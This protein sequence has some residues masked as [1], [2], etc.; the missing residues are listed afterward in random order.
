MTC[1]DPP[2]ISVSERA[3]KREISSYLSAA[4]IP[5][6]VG[7]PQSPARL[8]K[9]P[10][11]TAL[12]QLGAQR[13][14][15]DR[16]FFSLI[17][18]QHQYIVAEA[19]RSHALAKAG[20]CTPG[21]EIYLGVSKLDITFGVCPRTIAT[22]T[23]ETGTQVIRSPNVIGEKD[24][25]IIKDFV[26]DPHY[27]QCPYVTGF[28][29]MRSYA[30]VPITSPL[31]YVLGS[32]CVVHNEV[33]DFD[34]DATIFI[35]R[36]ISQTIMEHLDLVRIKQNRL[37]S[38]QLIKGLNVFVRQ[39]SQHD[40][41]AEVIEVPDASGD[42]SCESS[43]SIKAA[44]SSPSP[45]LAPSLSTPSTS[46]ASSNDS[47][48][49]TSATPLESNPFDSALPDP[50]TSTLSPSLSPSCGTPCPNDRPSAVSSDVT[51]AF[52]R[53]AALIRETMGMDGLV[54]L[55]ACSNGFD[56]TP[57]PG[58]SANP[59]ARRGSLVPSPVPFAPSLHPNVGPGN[60]DCSHCGPGIPEALLLRLIRAFPQGHIFSADE[61]GHIDEASVAGRRTASSGADVAELF[62]FL[63]GA[64]SV[65]FLPLWHFQR[66]SWFAATLGW[67][68]SPTR[69]FDPADLTFLAAFGNSVMAEVSR[70]EALE[71]SRAKS[72]FIS[73][74]SHELRS[75]LHGILASAELFK[76]ATQDPTLV[77]MIEMIE[78]C[79]KTLLDTFNNL[80]DFAKINNLTKMAPAAQESGQPAPTQATET[81]LAVLVQDVVETMHMGHL[82]KLAVQDDLSPL[83]HFT[84]TPQ[85]R[86]TLRDPVIVTIAIEPRPSWN[87]VLDI[88]AWKRIVM[89]VFGNA[90]K[91]TKA[92]HI[93]VGLTIALNPD[94]I[95]FSVRDS[96]IGMSPD[97]LKYQ[98]FTPFAQ[99]NHLSPG[100]GLGLS[101]VK[102]L[103]KSL[104][105]DLDVTSQ[106]GR[107]TTVRISVPLHPQGQP[108]F[109]LTLPPKSPPSPHPLSTL[110]ACY[111]PPS[112]L[113]ADV[114]TTTLTRARTVQIA[115]SSI[116]TGNLGMSFAL[117]SA[118]SLPAADVY[119][120]D[121]A[122]LP[123]AQ[124][125][126]IAS[127]VAGRLGQRVPI[128]ALA[129][130]ETKRPGEG[131]VW[132][133]HPL[134]PKKVAQ[135]VV[136]AMAA[137]VEEA[138]PQKP[139]RHVPGSFP[140]PEP[141]AVTVP[142]TS[143]SILESL[144]LITDAARGIAEA[145]KS[146]TRITDSVAGMLGGLRLVPKGS[147]K[148]RPKVPAK[149]SLLSS[150]SHS[151]SAPAA[152]LPATTTA[153]ALL[154]TTTLSTPTPPA[155]APGKPHLLLVDDNPLNLRILATLSLRLNCTY[156][157]CANGL[158]ALTSFKSTQT[159]PTPYTLVFMDISM[160]VMDGFAATRA[161]REWE[162][163]WGL[164][165][166]RI[167]ALTGLGSE[168]DREE[169]FRA[170]CEEF[171]VKPV[172]VGEVRRCLGVGVGGEA[173]AV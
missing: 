122:L 157:T 115:L 113:A 18:G 156:T 14:D 128:V 132:C 37:R 124:A 100:T 90:L 10:I 105:G 5:S 135:A 107:G 61:W 45:S 114:S 94:R 138:Q 54:F 22:F 39:G 40:P 12:V 164:K 50:N 16:A 149:P 33:R 46:I 32:Y 150:H 120:L 95:V 11:L 91:Y 137:A 125:A 143:G 80:L 6:D 60:A 127:L 82:S 142:E 35:L 43:S 3:R 171:L 167:V 65:I 163:E 9:D 36:E 146:I 1:L 145:A 70:F 99:E 136:A 68:T 7:L 47:T 155:T 42:S 51:R 97:Y 172:S 92:G 78:S 59:L 88:G 58:Y 62:T 72:D 79:G 2:N 29:Y 151:M 104:G 17:D 102:Q 118:S 173:V 23:D 133:R 86:P 116:L 158:A 24:R 73:S 129:W 140:P 67:V 64:R 98:L 13:L 66:E 57:S 4:C 89:N 111:L 106:L 8:S 160:P 20:H 126:D 83:G 77:S 159:T 101:I 123:H 108:T 55:D 34:N 166:V 139:V 41:D 103:V 52:T 84:P 134:G 165:P 21:D 28:P 56:R 85:T 76:E 53:A 48:L 154:P 144:G 69:A 112:F 15:V 27:R 152:V 110:R 168:G 141:A 169:A 117:A 26:A 38:E 25:Y 147:F 75:P 44:L 71:V 161:M 119:F 109:S 148:L 81:D 30:E 131:V 153:A 49:A 31:G 19:T 63:P 121:S 170:G 96:G 162:R 93:E 87:R 130:A 74:V